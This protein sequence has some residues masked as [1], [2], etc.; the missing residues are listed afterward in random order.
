MSIGEEALGEEFI[1]I[2]KV[3]RRVIGGELWNTYRGI[4]WYPLSTD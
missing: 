4:A 1:G 3:Q 2:D